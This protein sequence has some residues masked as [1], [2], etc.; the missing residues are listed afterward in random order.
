MQ[1]NHR[2]G[3]NMS[4]IDNNSI[5]I[6]VDPNTGVNYLITEKGG[7]CPRYT[8]DGILYLSQVNENS[9]FKDQNKEE[10]E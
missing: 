3:K 8:F 9:F 4:T 10:H 5:S 6:F 2:K 1:D 7:I